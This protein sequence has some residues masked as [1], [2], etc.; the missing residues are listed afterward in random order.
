MR[1]IMI[2]EDEAIVRI[3]LQ[4]IIDWN[5]HGFELAG[6]F[7]NGRQAWEAI[8]ENPPD[9]LLTDIRMPEMDGLELIRRIRE[10]GLETDI[11]ILSGYDDFDYTRKAIQLNVQDYLIK[12][13][14]DPAEIIETLNALPLRPRRTAETAE[15]GMTM[16]AEKA[17]LL[18]TTRDWPPARAPEQDFRVP[19]QP[20]P[21]LIFK[22]G[23]AAA[24]PHL[25]WIAMRPSSPDKAYL[26]SELKA[27]AMLLSDIG[28][29]FERFVFL[30]TDKEMFH[31][32]G[33]FPENG[34]EAPAEVRGWVEEELAP[35]LRDKL[36]M[37]MWTGI[38]PIV[39]GLE[40]AG[41]SRRGAEDALKLSFYGGGPIYD[42]GAFGGLRGLTQQER[43]N[44]LKQAKTYL[45]N[46]DF[47]GTIG[48][49][50]AQKER[51]A[52]GIDPQ[53]AIR[54]C[55]MVVHQCADLVMERYQIDLLSPDGPLQAD[56]NPL[57][58]L[59]TAA[60]WDSLADLAAEFLAAAGDV[61]GRLRSRNDWLG[62][63]L[64][65]IEENYAKPFRQE[66]VAR[67]VH[68]SVN[69]FS[70]R[71]RQETGVAFSDYVARRRIHKAI[72][73]A[74]KNEE[75]ST[76]EIAEKAGFSNPNYFIRLFKKVTGSTWSEFKRK[77]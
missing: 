73:L 54:F 57:I 20:F 39:S 66:D 26:P 21:Q 14:L 11:V 35:P 28:N 74:R 18:K 56:R 62:K 37:E 71:F 61:V 17:E 75:W 52:A 47:A 45:G 53:D 1:K 76:E 4:T 70:Y 23:A 5:R 59:E 60:S 50:R 72:E 69:Y 22:L 44:D 65:Y 7:S 41:L 10:A 48:W 36:N 15:A 63:A 33:M 51:M 42:A 25:I 12:H 9:I 38:G 58:K 43:L 64:A 68:F 2:A 46:E 16:E 6:A 8:R 27:A 24:N 32:L 13:K 29:R 49:L 3:G 34:E 77:K 19:R 55:R 40:H 30:G 31:A 67:H